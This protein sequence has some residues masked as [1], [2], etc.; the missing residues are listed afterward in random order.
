M[1]SMLRLEAVRAEQ[2]DDGFVVTAESGGDTLKSHVSRAMLRKFCEGSLRM[3]A[4]IER[5]APGDDA[6]LVEPFKG[7]PRIL[8]DEVTIELVGGH[9]EGCVRSGD[10][11][12]RFC[13]TPHQ[14]MLVYVRLG[15]VIDQIVA[16]NGGEVRPF[17]H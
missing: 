13:A 17:K 2:L 1:G 6:G 3:L 16:G 4:G 11:R 8:I 9:V 10:E 5:D 15:E 12:Q 7:C 14:G